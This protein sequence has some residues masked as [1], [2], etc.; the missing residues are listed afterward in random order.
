MDFKTIESVLDSMPRTSLSPKYVD[1]T[2]N[3]FNYKLSLLAW[4]Q[5]DCKL[6]SRLDSRAT[7][8]TLRYM[9]YKFKNGIFLSLT[10]NKVKAFLSFSNESY[11]NEFDD[12]IQK[13]YKSG[14][15]PKI[16][17]HLQSLTATNLLVFPPH[18]WQFENGLITVIDQ[19]S[20]IAAE[21]KILQN[22]TIMR[23]MFNEFANKRVISDA[24]VFINIHN[25]P[26]L[27]INKMEPYN[28]LYGSDYVPLRS[29]SYNTYSPILSTCGSG[30]YADIIIPTW[31]DWARVVYQKSSQ[32]LMKNKQFP[33][34]RPSFTDAMWMRK[35]E[36]AV[37]RGSSSGIG[38]SEKN[39]QR[40]K[41]LRLSVE[42]PSY[43]DVGITK[44]NLQQ[45]RKASSD[46]NF[47]IIDNTS[48]ISSSFPPVAAAAKLSLQEQ[49]D[50]Y[51]YILV[52]EGNVA[53]KRLSY[54]LSSS[55]VILLAQSKWKL[56][57]T[58]HLK[59]FVHYVPIKEDLSDL[60][61][62][63][64]WCRQ[65]DKEC[66]N[67]VL[68]ANEFYRRY[69]EFD[70]I[71]DYLQQIFAEIS[72]IVGAYK[73][74]PYPKSVI[75]SQ[76]SKKLSTKD[77]ISSGGGVVFKFPIRPTLNR[78]IGKLDACLNVFRSKT[79]EMQFNPI[80]K[81]SKYSDL[82]STNGFYLTRSTAVTTYY[83]LQHAAY[84]G[85]NAVNILVSKC[86]NYHYTYGLLQSK[87][88]TEYISNATFEDWLKDS[89][90]FNVKEFCSILIQLN[91]ALCVGQTY[92]AFVHN[93]LMPHNIILQKLPAA[94]VSFD[95]HV[96]M[97]VVI[98]YTT[99]IIPIINNYHRS[100]AVI[101]ESNEYGL[102]DHCS[103]N[104]FKAHPLFDT[105]TI[106]YTSLKILMQNNR[107]CVKDLNMLLE[108]GDYIELS[109]NKQYM[110]KSIELLAYDINNNVNPDTMN[111][112]TFIYFLES[113][114]GKFRE[115]YRI[116]EQAEEPKF[117]MAKGVPRYE[118]ALMLHGNDYQAR[119]ELI[120]AMNLKRFPTY[121]DMVTQMIN[122]QLLQR[123]IRDV[124][125]IMVNN[126]SDEL[127]M[128]KYNKVKK[129][130]LEPKLPTKFQSHSIEINFPTDISYINLDTELNPEVFEDIIGD[131]L[132]PITEDW[133]VIWSLCAE[134]ALFDPASLDIFDTRLFSSFH[135]L[136][137]VASHNTF[138][139]L[140][141]E[142]TKNVTQPSRDDDVV[143]Q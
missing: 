39:N 71:L 56:W 7:F 12:L 54:Y 106:L 140:Y 63:I 24:E 27:R 109:Y 30:G 51:K 134:S 46:Q 72:S 115:M 105:S 69:L 23:D 47:T 4:D 64:E 74:A 137:A 13:E 81:L 139:K 108:W 18:E 113:R 15:L 50:N 90:P 112:V 65:N 33:K 10:N 9:F 6:Y 119:Q 49:S 61:E 75:L 34:I 78:C 70:G 82:V 16:L 101:Y 89:G 126:K 124:D 111:P 85:L 143:V 77:S 132:P 45:I 125:E 11:I 93:D 14:N 110:P 60:V 121:D 62:K 96:G 76:E 32:Q 31:Y 20:L 66:K 37:F 142:M 122:I 26:I 58:N 138:H 80:K 21:E 97:G 117:S 86:P 107:I 99:N 55:S 98:R 135:M 28:N 102:I 100:R 131:I 40:L 129:L 94:P 114:F 92:C 38:S 127:T 141:K 48:K 22:K 1:L 42:N 8:N 133:S 84:I 95:Y 3:V 2:E 130:I 25:S 136:N 17:V 59:P 120:Y 104:M 5:L 87:L 43:L 67:I 73:Y 103:W 57:F 91:L 128:R 116:N 29:H 41:A 35:K 53:A 36:M 19:S 118:T 83:Q 68:N 52:L 44:W 123:R 88:Y 79:S